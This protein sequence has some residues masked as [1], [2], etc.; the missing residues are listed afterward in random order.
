MISVIII[1]AYCGFRSID[2]ATLYLTEIGQLSELEASAFITALGYL[3]IVVAFAAG[4]IADKITSTKLVTIL[5]IVSMLTQSIL[6]GFFPKEFYQVILICSNFVI[7]FL[8]IVSLRAVYF[9][10][11]NLSELVT[12]A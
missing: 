9:S 7:M 5:F 8:A 6:Y 4:F 2:N 3:R 12:I 11:I 1:C 10:L